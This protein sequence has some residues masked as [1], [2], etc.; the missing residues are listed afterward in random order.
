[1][2]DFTKILKE[3]GTP[4]YVYDIDTLYQRVDYLK[5]KLGNRYDLVY[6]V[7]ANS[8]IAKHLENKVARF[9]ICSPGEFDIC[10]QLGI[11]HQKMV[12]S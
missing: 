5:S 7:K 2:I 1:M 10:D 12:I 4:S 8:F 11:S 6:A 9:E 3:Y